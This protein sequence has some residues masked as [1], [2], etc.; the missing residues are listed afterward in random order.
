MPQNSISIG[1][2][3]LYRLKEVGIETI[4]G[5]PGDY[6]MVN[7]HNPLER[8]PLSRTL[9]AEYPACGPFFSLF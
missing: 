9:T 3:L 8:A 7:F 2:Y 4:F 5:V 6:N 1:K